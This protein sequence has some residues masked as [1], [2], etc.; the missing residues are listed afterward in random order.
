MSSSTPICFADEPIRVG[1]GAAADFAGAGSATAGLTARKANG[2]DG[3]GVQPAT[4]NIAH[5]TTSESVNLH[6]R[7]LP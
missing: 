2:A 7:D 1:L 6:I 3:S 5:R 4:A